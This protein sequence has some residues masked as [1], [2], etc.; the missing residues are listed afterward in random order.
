MNPQPSWDELEP[1][2]DDLYRPYS[3]MHGSQLSD[4]QE[5][6]QANPSGRFRHISVPKK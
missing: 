5:I 1:Y 2:Y 3:I 6:E 4:E